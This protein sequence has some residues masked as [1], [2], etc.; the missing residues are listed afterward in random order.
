ARTSGSFAGR[1]PST[2]LFVPAPT[3]W[4]ASSIARDRTAR[5]VAVRCSRPDG[6]TRSAGRRSVLASGGGPPGAATWLHGKK[7]FDPWRL[8]SLPVRQLRSERRPA[9]LDE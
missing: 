8:G 4:R 9:K 2:G 1:R 3:F 7:H 5:R 6:D